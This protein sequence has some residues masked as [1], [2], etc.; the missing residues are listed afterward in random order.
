MLISRHQLSWTDKSK[1]RAQSGTY[2]CHKD[3]SFLSKMGTRCRQNSTN[4][5]IPRPLETDWYR[6]ECTNEH[7]NHIALMLIS[8]DQLS[9][10][11]RSKSRA[12]IG[13]YWCHSDYC[14]LTSKMETRR[15]KVPLI[16]P[17]LRTKIRNT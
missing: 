7:E 16:I 11:N 2:W 3:R 6:K 1:S 10:I 17:P 4:I 15:R 9:W 8:R 12:E 14:R 5:T 13:V